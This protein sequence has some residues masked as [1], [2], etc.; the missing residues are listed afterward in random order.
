MRLFKYELKHRKIRNNFCLKLHTSGI[1]NIRYMKKIYII[2]F[3]FIFSTVLILSSCSSM[4]YTTL[5]VLRPAKVTFAPEVKNVLIVNN[6][7]LQPSDFGHKTELIREKTRNVSLRTDSLALFALASLT[8]ELRN[9]EFFNNV[10]LKEKS[11]NKSSD[12]FYV[13]EI[14]HDSVKALTKRYK[15]DAVVSLNRI[16]VTDRITEYYIES[17][18]IYIAE[19]NAVYET[20]WSIHL[21]RDNKYTVATFRDTVFWESESYQRKK[22]LDG[23]PKREDALIDGALYSGQSTAKKLIPNWEKTDR[24]FFHT[25]NKYMKQAMDS[26][27]VKNWQSAMDSWQKITEKAYSNLLKAKAS[28]NAGIAAEITG[29]IDKAIDLVSRSLDYFEKSLTTDFESFMLVS[30]YFDELLRRKKEIEMVRKQL[31]E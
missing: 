29:D 9:R 14:S 7:V 19:L 12:F 13:K 17:E 8:E 3:L 27:Y 16:K 10:A 2:R 28:Y 23:L 30:D 1:Q 21:P 18:R 24:Y 20:Q 11:I 31:G 4:R 25:A 26:V 15:T 6:S 22:A 5:D